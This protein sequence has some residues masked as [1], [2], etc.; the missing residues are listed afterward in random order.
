MDMTTQGDKL[1]K[2]C[3]H[4]KIFTII[5]ESRSDQSITYYVTRAQ[6][7]IHT[8]NNVIA[9]RKF[10]LSFFYFFVVLLLTLFGCLTCT[11]FSHI[12]VL[13]PIKHTTIWACINFI[14]RKFQ[15]AIYLF[16]SIKWLGNFSFPIATKSLKRSSII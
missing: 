9:W 3:K 5:L 14:V 6:T 13:A 1:L 11:A 15:L 12:T 10:P 2:N 16:H 8:L 7:D 4:N